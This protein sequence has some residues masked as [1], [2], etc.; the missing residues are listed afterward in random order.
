MVASRCLF[1]C[2]WVIDIQLLVFGLH[3][4]NVLDLL[5][6]ACWAGFGAAAWRESMMTG[7][8]S[9]P[10]LGTRL[11][12]PCSVDLTVFHSRPIDLRIPNFQVVQ[13]PVMP[14]T[15]MLPTASSPPGACWRGALYPFIALQSLCGTLLFELCAPLSW[16]WSRQSCS[17][18]LTVASAAVDGLLPGIGRLKRRDQWGSRRSR[19]I[20]LA[21]R[22]Y[23]VWRGLPLL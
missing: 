11:S 21:R 4:R 9:A 18:D 6:L 15:M 1:F 20:I 8:K 23:S 5:H 3:L 12:L 13:P 16:S 2:L 10:P 7:L 17:D 22:D 19:R 14:D